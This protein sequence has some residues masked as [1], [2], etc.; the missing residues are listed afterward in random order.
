MVPSSHDHFRP[1]QIQSYG[2]F[3][4]SGVAIG[5]LSSYQIMVNVHGNAQG[6]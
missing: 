5:P 3:L 6:V 4:I 2:Q 1:F